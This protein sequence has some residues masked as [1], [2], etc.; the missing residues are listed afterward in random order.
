MTKILCLLTFSLSIEWV[1]LQW[2]GN[3][4][5]KL[6]AID[7]QSPG[8]VVNGGSYLNN[9]RFLVLFSIIIPISLRVNLDMG[10]SAYT[11]FDDK[12]VRVAVIRTNNI[13]MEVESRVLS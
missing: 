7:P 2:I 8:G 10:R 13:P 3:N 6:D 11:W 5:D 12:G 4:Q 1:A 9:P